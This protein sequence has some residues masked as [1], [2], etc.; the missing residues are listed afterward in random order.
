[1]GKF[2]QN[3][4]KLTLPA[5]C[6]LLIFVMVVG[7]LT[8]V[9]FLI[10]SFIDPQTKEVSKFGPVLSYWNSEYPAFSNLSISV[11]AKNQSFA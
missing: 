2:P 10:E 8:G 9:Y 1:M 6:Y 3:D 7:V 11:H 4:E 5:K